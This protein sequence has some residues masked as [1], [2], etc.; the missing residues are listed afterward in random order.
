M[1]YTVIDHLNGDYLDVKHDKLN[2]KEDK[3]LK[4]IIGSYV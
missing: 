3:K 4:K 2:N 1:I